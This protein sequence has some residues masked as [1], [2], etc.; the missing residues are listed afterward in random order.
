MAL[1]DAWLKA[2]HGKPRD[3]ATE[4]GDRDGM[5]ARVSPKGKITF[6]VRFMFAGKQQRIDLGTYPLISLKQAREICTKY[7]TELEKGHDPRIIK[8]T[9]KTRNIEVM[10]LT[11]VFAKWHDSYCVEN[12]SNSNEIKRSFEIHVFPKYGDI[13]P[14]RISV[15]Q[16]LTLLEDIK[17]STPAIAERILINAKQMLAWALRRKLIESNDLAALTPKRDLSIVKKPKTR[18][19]SDDEIRWL[20]IALD[21]SRIAAKNKLF[22]K[23]CLIYGCRNGE[24][25]NAKKQHFDFESMVW[26][27]PHENHKTG[28]ITGQPLLRPI[29]AETEKFIK[30]AIA[31][32]NG[33]HVFNNEGT[34][35]PMG[36]RA[37]GALPYNVMQCLRKKYK[38]EMEHWS[39]H[40]LRKTARTNFST[41][42]Q[43]HIAEIMLGH[44]LP[45]E[46]RTYDR[47]DYLKEQAE[48]IERW[49]ARIKQITDG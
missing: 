30:L 36:M 10:T 19:L 32:S 42:T 44:A 48:C 3:S 38:Y 33:E 2:N 17:K 41:L 24:L 15:D 39:I 7:R 29:T 1:T 6:Q 11:A 46:W 9:A 18:S 16:W 35:E 27:V 8:K 13:P 4:K 31:L 49:C 12:K 22:I 43:P 14:D 40:D 37:P 28:K 34:D 20:Y 47:H 45:G 25:R 23:L 26:T 5:G 21:N